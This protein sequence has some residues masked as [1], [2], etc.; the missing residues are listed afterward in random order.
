LPAVYKW[1]FRQRL[2]HWYARLKEVEESVAELER[3]PETATTAATLHTK[4]DNIDDAVGRLPVPLQFA[5]QF[6]N[7]R[8][9]LD[10][11]RERLKMKTA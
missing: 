9:H 7:L 3:G 5:E 1:R 11:V 8:N 6:Y 2:L 4:L 10:L